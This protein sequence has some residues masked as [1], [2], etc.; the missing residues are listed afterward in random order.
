MTA[1][2]A[3]F[4][5]IFGAVV[6]SFLNAC[7]HR[8]P[9]GISL[10]RPRRSFCPSC[11]ATI[12]WYHNLPVVSWLWLRGRCARCGAPIAP[13]YLLVEV[14]TG[15]LFLAVWLGFGLP[16]APAYAVF[17]ALLVVATFIDFEH[18]IIPDEI[19]LGGA[20][21]GLVLSAALPGL[22]GVSSHLESTLLALA[23]AALGAGVL[24]LVVEGGKLAFGRKRL[25]PAQPEPFHF[26]S[27]EENPRL[28]LGGE[29]WPWADIF[30]RES[31]AL[32]IECEHA[33]FNGRPISGGRIRVFH[34]R[35]L[36]GG[37][38]TSLEDVRELRGVLRAVVI[39][40]EAMGLGDVKFMACIGAFVGWQ[41][42]LFTI[43][44]ASIVGAVVGGGML[45]ATRGRA[46]GKI[47]FGPYL[48]LGAALWVA[49]GPPL[50][51]WYLGLLR[52]V[53]P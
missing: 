23:G 6:G 29:V 45:L 32:V 30:S 11:Q 8:L 19:T 31:D 15:A 37:V 47:P 5:F 13:R 27:D 24:W 44:A 28:V 48:A 12:A 2:L 43:A 26:E 4:A 51:G 7:I 38:E 17:A 22:M 3:A 36:A 42:V 20:V 52:P 53:A 41:G 16:L 10:D 39:P 34:N 40:R 49:V 25:V 50:V 18:Y 46:G 33:T 21:A 1:V 14:L 35:I 9:R